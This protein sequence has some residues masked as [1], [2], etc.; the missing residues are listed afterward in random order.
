MEV[1]LNYDRVTKLRTFDIL[2]LTALELA[3]LRTALYSLRET[4]EN[5]L[6]GKPVAPYLPMQDEQDM[7]RDMYPKFQEAAQMARKK[8]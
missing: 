8:T 4:K 7:A 1:K 2:G 5:P 3:T 6:D